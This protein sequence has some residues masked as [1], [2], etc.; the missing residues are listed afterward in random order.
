[1]I[2]KNHDEAEMEQSA[3]PPVSLE[4]LDKL[5]TRASTVIERLPDRL[6]AP[7]AQKELH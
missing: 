2:R 7:G 5:A 3:L 6:Y 4:E 1:M